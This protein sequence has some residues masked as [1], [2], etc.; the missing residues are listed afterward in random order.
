[1]VKIS[2]EEHRKK[3]LQLGTI[4]IALVTVSDS[5]REE[6][7]EN[8]QYLKRQIQKARHE[9]VAYRIVKDEASQ[10]EGVLEE[11]AKTPARIIIFNGGTG[12]SRRDRTFDVLHKRFEK[13]LP[14]FGEIFRM[15]SF[16]QVGAAAMLSRAAAGIYKDKVVILIPGSPQAVELAWKKLIEPELQHLAWELTR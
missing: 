5:R 2:S 7:D 6:T 1:M 11:F 3:A 10:V 4:P 8:G 14:G 12:I 15:L 13:V 16:E 9:V